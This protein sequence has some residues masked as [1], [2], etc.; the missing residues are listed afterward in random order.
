MDGNPELTKVATEAGS[1]VKLTGQGLLIFGTIFS[2]ISSGAINASLSSVR[3]L[4][5]ITHLF[6]MTL[7]IEGFTISFFR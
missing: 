1:G 4:S 5:L 3:S 7:W 6:L 2:I